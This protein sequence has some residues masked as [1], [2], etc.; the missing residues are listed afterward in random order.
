MDMKH[1]MREHLLELKLDSGTDNKVAIQ[2]VQQAMDSETYGA[3]EYR[4]TRRK[5]KPSIFLNTYANP[6]KLNDFVVEVYLYLGLNYIEKIQ[7]NKE[8]KEY[9]YLWSGITGDKPKLYKTLAGAEKIMCNQL[10]KN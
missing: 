6:P 9:K 1:L 10:F 2:K 5:L 8:E 7:P 4:M 3:K